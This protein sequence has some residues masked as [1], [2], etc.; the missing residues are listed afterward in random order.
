MLADAATIRLKRRPRCGIEAGMSTASGVIVCPM[1]QGE[2]PPEAVFCGHPGCGKALGEFRY[3]REELLAASVWYERVADRVSAF[4]GKPQ[5]LALHAFWFLFW[6]TVNTGVFALVSRFDDYPF[7]LLGIILSIEAIFITG[8]LL[9]SQ[10]RQNAHADKRAELDYEVNVR[11]YREINEIDTM[12]RAIL[13]RLDRL[14]ATR[15]T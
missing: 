8:F 4:V 5:F 7:G 6:V 13:A 10:N 1:C 3:V 2:N 11:T 12:L 15:R 14:E 9:I